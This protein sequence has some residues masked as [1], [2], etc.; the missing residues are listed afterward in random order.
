MEGHRA[1]GSYSDA[2]FVG[3]EPGRTFRDACCSW[4]ARNPNIN[5]DP[6]T[7]TFWGCKLFPSEGE[8]RRSFG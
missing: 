6:S 3:K 2:T 7:L 4:Y 8:A 5:F 1:T